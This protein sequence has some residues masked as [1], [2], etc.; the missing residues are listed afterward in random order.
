MLLA[1]WLWMRS[2]S[3]QELTALRAA[4]QHPGRWLDMRVAWLRLLPL[5][6]ASACRTLVRVVDQYGKPVEAAQVRG[7][8]GSFGFS[9][10]SV[11][12][13]QGYARVDLNLFW[14]RTNCL[15][16]TTCD[17]VEWKV[18]GWVCPEALRLG[19][20]ARRLMTREEM[21]LPLGAPRQSEPQS[22]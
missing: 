10:P 12:D 22:P 18:T 6:F 16:I 21:F 11:T 8:F 1:G 13:S 9:D 20:N 14:R 15:F 2:N 4:A 3:V 7:Y 19:G 17:G 5:I